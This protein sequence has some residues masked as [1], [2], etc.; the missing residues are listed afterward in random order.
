VIILQKD[1]PVVIGWIS[2][3]GFGL[4][5]ATVLI[6]YQV[7]IISFPGIVTD[8]EITHKDLSGIIDLYEGTH[9]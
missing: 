8:P 7:E 4:H 3:D 9:R 6:E 2:W 1:G 5:K